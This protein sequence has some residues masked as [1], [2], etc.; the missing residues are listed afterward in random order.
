MNP[1]IFRSY[2]I[3]GVY[4]Q[5][6]N[7][8]DAEILGKAYGT[9]IQKISGPNIIIGRDNRFSSDE[10]QAKFISGLLSTGCSVT[11]SELTLRPFIALAVIKKNF[12]GGVL[13]TASHNPPEYNGFKFFKQNGVP[14]FGEEL[15]EIKNLYYSKE[16]K[17]GIGNIEY[18]NIFNLYLN[19]IKKKIEHPLNFKVVIDCGNGTASKFA[20]TIFN[21]LGCKV[22]TLYCNLDGSYP[23]HTPNPE[24]VGN[25]TELSQK[26][27]ETNADIGLAYDSDGDRF[28]IADEKGKFHENDDTLI[29]LAKE[30]L[31]QNR[32]ATILFDIKSSYTLES[33]IEKAGGKGIMMRTGHPYF[34]KR[35]LNNPGII[36]GAEVS[37]HTM[38]KENYCIDDAIYASA[39]LLETAVKN[40]KTISELYKPIP[41]TA[42]T[43]EITAPCSDTEKF[44]IVE[45]IKE[46]YS[47]EYEIIATDGVRVLF[48]ETNWALIRAS[49]TTPSIS[50]R[51][52]ANTQKALKKIIKDVKEKLEKY[53]QVDISELDQYF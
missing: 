38:F 42:H 11:D 7:I 28:G 53:P 33:E 17:K 19:Y 45:K 10:L 14:I 21:N 37:G 25:V 4:N 16:F 41:H 47:K 36:L 40:K 2:D 6:F 20:P 32:G 18:K 5:D 49:H 46:E 3:R 34:Q 23:Y 43:P 15:L 48:T 35:M 13:I 51:F 1:H 30:L 8:E 39:K 31:K 50:M 26:V 44:G 9:Y 29:V 27:V 12:D 24:S 22:E 52:E